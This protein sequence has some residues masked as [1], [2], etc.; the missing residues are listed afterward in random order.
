MSRKQKGSANSKKARA[1]LARLHARIANIRQD[2]LHQLTTGLTRRFPVIGIEDLNVAGMMKNRR[3]ARSIADR[4]FFE[5]RRQLD[6]KSE[7]RGGEVVVADRWFASSKTCSC[8]GQVRESLPLAVRTWTC[9]DCQARHDRDGNAAINLKH[10][11]VSST[12][13]ACGGEG[14]GP[15]GNARVKPAPSKQEVSKK[16]PMGSFG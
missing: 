7:M 8:C 14:A 11:A 2:A 10:Y 15:G 5:F 6:Y 9:P 16:L 1:R 12:V 4:G 3:L 13:S